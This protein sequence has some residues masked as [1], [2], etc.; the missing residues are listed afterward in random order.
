MRLFAFFTGMSIEKDSMW[1]KDGMRNLEPE[2]VAIGLLDLT[3]TINDDDEALAGML[4]VVAI[5]MEWRQESM[6]AWN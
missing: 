6:N 5:A 3:Q 2:T 4:K 1:N